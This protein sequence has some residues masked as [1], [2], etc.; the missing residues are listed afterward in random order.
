MSDFS[1]ASPRRTQTTHPMEQGPPPPP[2]VIFGEHLDDSAAVRGDDHAHLHRSAAHLAIGDKG[3]RSATVSVHG[4]EGRL[5]AI[6][7]A[8]GLTRVH[9]PSPL[10]SR[11]RSDDVS[12]VSTLER[13]SIDVRFP[14]IPLA[15]A[16][17]ALGLVR[18]I[19]IPRSNPAVGA[20]PLRSVGLRIL[21]RAQERTT[22]PCRGR[23]AESRVS[24][25]EPYSEGGDPEYR[26]QQSSL[27]SPHL[28]TS[29]SLPMI[30][31][32]LYFIH[33]KN[34]TNNQRLVSMFLGRQSSKTLSDLSNMTVMHKE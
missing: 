29:V 4:H 7:T 18:S 1:E 16:V 26:D 28:P 5:T 23:R 15:P 34:I 14:G 33:D 19:T 9:S 6:R 31:E 12:Q 11:R 24:Q 32:C 27:F 22:R 2:L 3:L 8:Q 13:A 17:R 21:G 25:A 20:N 30:F 10:A